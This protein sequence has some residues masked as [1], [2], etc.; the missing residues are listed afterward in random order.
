MLTV[1]A[2][3]RLLLLFLPGWL[4]SSTL[5]AIVYKGGTHK[6]IFATLKNSWLML[7][8]N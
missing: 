5:I 4:F 6:I 3:L 1:S 7:K 8:T 2:F